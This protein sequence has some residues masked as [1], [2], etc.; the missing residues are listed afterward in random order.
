MNTR[1]AMAR[2]SPIL[3][4]TGPIRRADGADD[5]RWFLSMSFSCALWFL[6]GR[7]YIYDREKGQPDLPPFQA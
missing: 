7:D 2:A 6:I 3:S 5:F 1:L 4:K